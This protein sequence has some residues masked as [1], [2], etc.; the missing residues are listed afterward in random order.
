MSTL[1]DIPLAE[2]PALP[3]DFLRKALGGAWPENY[4]ALVPVAAFQ[5]SV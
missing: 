1:D 5:S 3:L 2:L 4:Q